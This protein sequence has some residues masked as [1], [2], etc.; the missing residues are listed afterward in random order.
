MRIAI[1]SCIETA[2]HPCCITD[3][4]IVEHTAQIVAQR[5]PIFPG[6]VA[7]AAHTVLKAEPVNDGNEEEVE[8]LQPPHIVSF[9]IDNEYKL[10]NKPAILRS[11]PAPARAAE[12]QTSIK[13]D[14]IKQEGINPE[15]ARLYRMWQLK[16]G[17]P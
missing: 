1:V 15:L 16:E 6:C 7:C 3:N 12:Q 11:G 10:V 8:G 17:L 5:V 2:M 9:L 4:N 14:G 13:F